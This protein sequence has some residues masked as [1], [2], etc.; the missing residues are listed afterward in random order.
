MSTA[1]EELPEAGPPLWSIGLAIVIMLGVP[2]LLYSMSPA[3]PIREGDTVFA[4][5]EERVSLA[6]PLLY[7][8]AKF[9]DTCLLDPQDPLMV[10]QQPSERRDGTLLV[11]I[12]G[13]TKMEWPFCPPQAEVIVMVNQIAQKKDILSEAKKQILEWWNQ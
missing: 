5:G 6:R 11:K 1:H 8:S 2:L 7:G 4:Q 12:Q 3:G 13:K 10:V 9:D